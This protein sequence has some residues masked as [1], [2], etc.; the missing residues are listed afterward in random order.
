MANLRVF[1]F[2]KPLSFRIKKLVCS[3][4]CHLLILLPNRLQ[5]NSWMFK[6]RDTILN[7]FVYIF[8]NRD[9]SIWNMRF[10]F[11]LRFTPLM[12]FHHDYIVI[13]DPWSV[14]FLWIKRPS[15]FHRILFT[16]N[17]SLYFPVSSQT[18]PPLYDT[19]PDLCSVGPSQLLHCV[20]SVL[21]LRLMFLI[22]I[23]MTQVFDM[24]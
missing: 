6:V 15:P 14:S 11:L 20:W 2:I 4:F 1:R 8:Y 13:P 9:G 24:K 19:F 17:V 5:I 23:A 7:S 12:L 18:P 16:T 22:P 3:L 21:T 10:S